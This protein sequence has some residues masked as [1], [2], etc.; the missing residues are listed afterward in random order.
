MTDEN[1]GAKG[2]EKAESKREKAPV[3]GILPGDERHENI[4]FTTQQKNPATNMDD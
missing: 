4:E 1:Q 2:A 3:Q